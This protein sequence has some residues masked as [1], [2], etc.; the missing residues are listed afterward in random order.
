MGVLEKT[1]LEMANDECEMR[2][3][4]SIRAPV[5]TLTHESRSVM[6]DRSRFGAGVFELL[7]KHCA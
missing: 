1:F 2:G 3:N 7:F 5:K 6:H 4:V